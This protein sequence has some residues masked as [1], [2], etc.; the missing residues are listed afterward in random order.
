MFFVFLYLHIFK[1]LIII[2]YRLKKVWASGLLIYLL[3][4]LEAFMGYVLVWAQIRFWAAVVITSLLRVIPIWGSMIVMWIWRGF[5]VTGSTLKFFFV[6]HFLLPWFL[7]VIIMLHMIFLHRTGSTSR[8]YCHGDYDKVCF[9][10]Y[11]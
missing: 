10:P 6:L 3:V 2:R 7:L 8:L 1:G 9:G 4:I 5:G 11:Y